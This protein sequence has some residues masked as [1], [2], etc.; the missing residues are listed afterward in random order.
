MAEQPKAEVSAY[1][2][3]VDYKRFAIAVAL[4]VI[5]LMLPIPELPLWFCFC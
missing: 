4:F 2:R 3:C 5:I 1:D